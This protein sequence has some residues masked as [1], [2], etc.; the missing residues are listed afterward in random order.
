M[1][2]VISIIIIAAVC[3]GGYKFWEY[4]TELRNKNL[5]VSAKSESAAPVEQVPGMAPQLEASLQKA[6]QGGAQTLKQWL[7]NYR[8]SGLVKDPRL[9]SIELDYVLLLAREDSAEAKRIFAEV[10]KRTPANSPVFA[11][12]KALESTFQ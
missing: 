3:F 2:A 5:G 8:R 11:R 9:A 10:K 4:W 7:D 6:Q 1:K 12:V